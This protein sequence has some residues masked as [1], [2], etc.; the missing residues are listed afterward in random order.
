MKQIHILLSSKCILASLALIFHIAINTE[1]QLLLTAVIDQR[2][3]NLIL[4][5]HRTPYQCLQANFRCRAP[6][7]V[8]YVDPV[9]EV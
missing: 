2:F 5:V 8:R 7:K 4:P 1:C 3:S 6:V 9:S